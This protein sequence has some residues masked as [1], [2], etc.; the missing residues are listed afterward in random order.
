M[1]PAARRNH[2]DADQREAKAGNALQQSVELRLISDDSFENAVPMFVPERCG[3][4]LAPNEVRQL[5]LNLD[6]VLLSSHQI[7]T[8]AHPDRFDETIATIT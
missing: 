7:V 6:A 2:V 3:A 5:A 4:E 8:L 1:R